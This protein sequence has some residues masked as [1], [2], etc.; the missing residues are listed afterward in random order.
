MKKNRIIVI[1][2]ESKLTGESL[3]LLEQQTEI[4]QAKGIQDALSHLTVFSYHLILI[5]VKREPEI[6]CQ[7][8]EAIRKLVIT[9]MIVLL[10]DHSEMRN[11]IIQAGADVVLTQLC[12][13]EISLQVYALIRRY[14]EWKTERKEEIPIMVGKLEILPLQRTVEW[15]HKRIPVVKREFDFLHLLAST[16]GRVYTYSQIYQLVWQEYPHGDIT[17][18]IYCMVHRLKQK[19][20]KADV[21][22]EHIISSVKEVGYCLKVYKES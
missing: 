7:L 3:V 20:K 18:I 21:N 17:N 22:A 1:A 9:P 16:P 14:T 6:V 15:D 13:E 4:Y 11:K 8:V 5:A 2:D 10:P 19:L 12:T